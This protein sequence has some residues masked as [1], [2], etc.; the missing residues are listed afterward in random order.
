[1]NNA[2]TELKV[3]THACKVVS[4]EP[5]NQATFEVELTSLKGASL[6]FKA[7]QYLQLVL[8]VNN[9][10]EFQSLSYT[11]ASR[12]NPEQPTCLK[13]IIQK[14]SEF[15]AKVLSRLHQ[16]SNNQEQ[17]DIRLAMGNAFLQTSL[18]LPHVLVAAGSGISKIKC[19]TEE[20]LQQRPDANIDIYWS[21]R[22]EHDFFLLD[23]FYD[24]AVQY[25]NLNFI[26]I[27]ESAGINWSG[28]TGFIYQVIQETLSDLSKAQTYLCGSPNMVYGTIDKLKSLG[29]KEENCYSDVFEFAPRDSQVAV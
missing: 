19:I 24:W 21:N 17:V 28:Q 23:Q 5:L 14:T 3:A 11:I 8:D 22:N 16:L 1:M 2:A 10:G 7:G 26:P 12:F 29:L 4:V 18:D 27:L 20:I 13:L 9:D 15:S 25:K 6:G